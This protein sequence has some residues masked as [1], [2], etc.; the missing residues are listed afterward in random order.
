MIKAWEGL[1][2]I[3]KVI[4]QLFLGYFVSIIYRIAK[5][6]QKFELRTLLGLIMSFFIIGWIID[7]VT[8]LLSGKIYVLA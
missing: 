7:F 2:W 5:L 3:V 8:V 1:P 4:L 6:L